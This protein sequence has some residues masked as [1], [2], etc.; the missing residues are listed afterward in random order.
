MDTWHH[1]VS[2]GLL[3]LVTGCAA[4]LPVSQ[5]VPFS[6]FEVPPRG[7]KPVPL[8]LAC[9]LFHADYPKEARDANMTGT[10]TVTVDVNSNGWPTRV[11][12][13]KSSGHEPLDQAALFRVAKCLFR[14]TYDGDTPVPAT[15]DIDI[16]WKLEGRR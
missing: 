6:S 11:M 15:L 1:L 16:F 10:T 12:L 4:P 7:P 8:P 2:V 13:K 14:P 9:Q 3:A 5:K